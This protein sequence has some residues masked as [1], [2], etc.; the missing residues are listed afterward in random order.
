[1]ATYESFSDDYPDCQFYGIDIEPRTPDTVYPHNCIFERGDFLK[2]LPYPDNTFDL[3]HV[4]VTL[5]WLDSDSFKNLLKEAARVTKRGGFIEFLEQDLETTNTGPILTSYVDAW[6]EIQRSKN[7]DGNLMSNMETLLAEQGFGNIKIDNCHIPIG[8][9]A[10]HVG[11]FFLSA[12]KLFVLHTA[13]LTYERMNLR[14]EDDCAQLVQELSA[15][16]EQ[17]M[18]RASVY[19]GF[20]QKL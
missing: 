17:Y 19:F 16:C 8:K 20:A 5:L 18:P 4:R 14:N 11:E 9:W 2:S 3:L 6:R 15:E 10:G 12:F 7:I 13:S 1:M